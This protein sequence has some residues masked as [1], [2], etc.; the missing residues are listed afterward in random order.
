MGEW[1]LPEDHF[2]EL[3]DEIEEALE[4][5]SLIGLLED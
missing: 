2:D 5:A 3:Q 4:L 1:T